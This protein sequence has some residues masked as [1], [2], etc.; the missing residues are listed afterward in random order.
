M[1]ILE[2]IWF[3]TTILIVGLILSSDPK[4]E[5]TGS[6]S[7]QLSLIFTS[8]SDGQKALRTFTWFLI[9]IFFTLS[10]LLSYLN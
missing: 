5:S 10:I 4:S 2:S 1:T 3:V 8:T 9:S 6:G 7:N